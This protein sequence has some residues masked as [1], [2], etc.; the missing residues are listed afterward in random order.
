MKT[1]V[2]DLK[3]KVYRYLGIIKYKLQEEVIHVSSCTGFP[4]F[5]SPEFLHDNMPATTKYPSVTQW[6][7]ENVI[8]NAQKNE[9]LFKSVFLD[10]PDRKELSSVTRC[11]TCLL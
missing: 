7:G 8:T 4:V 3:L 11:M 5:C 6:R 1:K 10:G 9:K 2:H